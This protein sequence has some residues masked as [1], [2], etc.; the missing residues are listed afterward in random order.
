MTEANNFE[1]RQKLHLFPILE[2]SAAKSD[3][4]IKFFWYSW[5][6]SNNHYF[7]VP[8]LVI[9][10]AIPTEMSTKTPENFRLTLRAL[11]TSKT[12][13]MQKFLKKLKNSP[14]AL[15]AEFNKILYYPTNRFIKKLDAPF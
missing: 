1:K 5:S 13:F 9:Y 6:S 8:W 7:G 10:T 2:N 14:F 11:D 4:P 3:G 15:L 12:F